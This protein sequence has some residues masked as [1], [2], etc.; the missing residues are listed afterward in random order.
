MPILKAS[1]KGL[2][3]S[4]TRN[5]RNSNIKRKMKEILKDFELMVKE[6]KMDEAK[7]NLSVVYKS[8][9]LAA[10]KNVYHQNKSARMKSRYAKML[11][12]TTE[13]KT[14]ATSKTTPAKKKPVA[15]KK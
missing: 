15:K 10:K 3:Q 7:A 9:D 14:E 13:A 11:D 8:L 4:K 6:G 5:E 12:T 1:I 2:R